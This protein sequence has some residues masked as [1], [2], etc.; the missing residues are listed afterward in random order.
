MFSDSRV[1]AVVNTCYSSRG[2]GVRMVSN[3]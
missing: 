1:N 3:S 2:T